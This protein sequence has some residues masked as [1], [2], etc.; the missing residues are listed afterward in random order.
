MANISGSLSQDLRQFAKEMNSV[1]NNLRVD[2]DPE[3]A[4]HVDESSP[5]LSGLV[6]Y[7]S[8]GGGNISMKVSGIKKKY[9]TSKSVKTVSLGACPIF[10]V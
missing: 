4:I 3:S 9:Q 2:A 7:S 8:E 1:K 6:A 5:T 10:C